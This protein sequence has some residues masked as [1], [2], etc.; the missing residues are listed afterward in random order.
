[1]TTPAQ[2]ATPDLAARF[3]GMVTPDER[4]GYSGWIVA[5]DKLL[6]FA[7]SLRDELGYDYLASVTGVDYLPA[8]KM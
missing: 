6:A 2:L 8:G 5:A 3:P 1:M 7:A 4:P